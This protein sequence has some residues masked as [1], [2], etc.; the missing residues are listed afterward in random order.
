MKTRIFVYIAVVVMLA[1]FFAFTASAAAQQPSGA[2]AAALKEAAEKPTP[3]APDGHPNLSG[4]W[5]NPPG[6]APQADAARP[7][8]SADGKTLTLGGRDVPKQDEDAQARFKARAA[9]QSARPPYKKEFVAKQR[10]LMYTASNRDPGLVC[11]PLGVP[12]LGAPAE[13]VQKPTVAY[14]LYDTGSTLRAIPIGKK[15]PDLL[16]DSKVWLRTDPLDHEPLPNGDS[17]ARWE[18]DTLVVESS[19][20]D[21]ETWLDGDGDFHSENMRVIERL[22]RKGNTL[23][24][25]VTVEDPDLFTEPW[26]PVGGKVQGRIGSRTL[27]LGGPNDHA[28]QDYPCIE[29]D[30]LH[31]VN[32][33]R[34]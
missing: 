17:T 10:E 8:Y 6:D 28:R 9:D 27:I 21:S 7:T 24:Y 16:S 29:R 31:K 14:F 18:G 2:S 1:A 19:Y 34:F 4:F 15:L 23:D 11:Y 5:T 33:D 30:H 13:I 3:R 25:D 20:F 22:T 32:N 26:K 12:R